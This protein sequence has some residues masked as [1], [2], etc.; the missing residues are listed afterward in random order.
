MKKI[1][2]F[3][4][5]T[6]LVAHVVSALPVSD[7]VAED[8]DWMTYFYCDFTDGIPEG[9]A[10][11]DR[12]GKT[13][14]FQMT[15]AGLVQG[16]AWSKI[17]EE[18]STPTNYC[19][20]SGS[21]HKYATGE[22]A[23]AADDWMVT[24][25]IW[26]KGSDAKL[27]WRSKSMG[28]SKKKSSYSVYVSTTGNTPEDFTAAAIKEVVDEDVSEWGSYEVSLAQYEGQNI[29]IAFVN[30]SLGKEILA[31]DDIKVEGRKG[32]CELLVTI[33]DYVF[34][35]EE[36]VVS[37][38]L[39]AYSDTE[40]NSFTAFYE[41]KGQTFSKQIS[42]IALKRLDT[43]SFTFDEK[44]VAA[45]GD[46]VTYKVWAEVGDLTTDV[47]ECKTIPLL[48]NPKRKIVV[49][50]GTGMW[51][52]YCPKGIV[53]ME[54]LAKR[55]PDSFIGVTV[56][57]DDALEVDDYRKALDFPGFPSARI[58]RKYLSPDIMKEV[59]VNGRKQYTMLEGG[60]ESLYLDAL[61]DQT[62]ADI[63]LYSEVADG[64]IKATVTTRFAIND[65]DAKYQIAIVM[66]ENDVTGEG[67]YQANGYADKP[68]AMGG[69]ENLPDY[70][71]DFVFQ[72]VARDIF[73]DFNGIP[74]SIPTNI[75]AGNENVFEF[76]V[77]VP[78]NVDSIDKTKIIAMLIN[79]ETG[80]IV[81]AEIAD[82]ASAGVNDVIADGALGLSYRI[83]GETC[84]VEIASASAASA[85]IALYGINGSKLAAASLNT[86]DGKASYSF[87]IGGLSGIHFVTV[88]QG[89]QTAAIKVAF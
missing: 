87:E 49:E 19:A 82:A 40:I 12:D 10:D 70:I 61:D 76:S 64:R 32:L 29:Y 30:N 73:D 25:G 8:N 75:I 53:A 52:T 67:F 13:F 3:I 37:A 1:I 65:D 26:V 24:T 74:G 77:E 48:F 17:V 59:L 56:H 80:E 14:H 33:G 51:C 39:T 50:E 60:I 27:S 6:L 20:A 22:E 15:Q 86:I 85:G 47:I 38:S 36:I 69:Y 83:E 2:A 35:T 71:L 88:R 42:G 78:E 21:K 11:Y 28:E 58:N 5:S 79:Q 63:S 45:I 46:T 89:N 57:Y 44:I 23:V 68:E 72:E 4:I 54:E 81:N 55:Y 43:H 16:Q 9:F 66:I 62:I 41:H 31:I 84:I 18:R 34:G 7:S